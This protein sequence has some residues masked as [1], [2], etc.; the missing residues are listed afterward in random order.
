MRVRARTDAN[1][2]KQF[3]GRRQSRSISSRVRCFNA[4]ASRSFGRFSPPPLSHS[5]SVMKWFFFFYFVIGIIQKYVRPPCHCIVFARQPRLSFPKIIVEIGFQ[6]AVPVAR[7][8]SFAFRP[9]GLVLILLK[10]A[11]FFALPPPPFTR[12]SAYWSSNLNPPISRC[13]KLDL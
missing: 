12:A 10:F 11:G 9:I 2:A 4:F 13:S 6:N 7:R 5:V 8:S 3:E 1:L